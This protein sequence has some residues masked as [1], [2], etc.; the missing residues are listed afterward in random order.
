MML[1]ELIFDTALKTEGVGELLETL[2][3]NQPAYLTPATKSGS[4]LRLACPKLGGF[5]IYA[6]CQ[7]T[8]I[9]DFQNAYPDDFKYE[10]NRAVHFQAGDKLPLKKLEMLVRSALTY[11]L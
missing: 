3:W 4:T 6:H 9:S 7:T 5:A 10:G 11:H 2:K 1:R 8:I